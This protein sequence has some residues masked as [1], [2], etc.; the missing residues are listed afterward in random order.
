MATE[1]RNEP[2][3][4]S[5]FTARL[6]GRHFVANF[7]ENSFPLSSKSRSIE[8]YLCDAIDRGR[9]EVSFVELHVRTCIPA[10]CN[11]REEVFFQGSMAS[12]AMSN[13]T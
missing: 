11:P 4:G 12:L 3:R 7:Y 1:S 9:H 8:S 10:G 2:D 6:H 13:G 5:L